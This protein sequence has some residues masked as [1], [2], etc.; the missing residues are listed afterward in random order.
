MLRLLLKNYSAVE[1]GLSN[2][3]LHEVFEFLVEESV[4]AL[5]RAVAAMP[6]GFPTH[7]SDP[8][9][10]AYRHRLMTLKALI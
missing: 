6:A 9:V 4:A 10:E 2:A 3:L 1:C 5:D 8:I 7:I